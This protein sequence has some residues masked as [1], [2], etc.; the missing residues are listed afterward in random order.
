M[1]RL[2]LCERRTSLEDSC[3]TLPCTRVLLVSNWVSIVVPDGPVSIRTFS[4]QKR[5]QHPDH[6]GSII[7]QPMLA[8]EL[9]ELTCIRLAYQLRIRSEG[10][11][12][13]RGVFRTVR[14]S[15]LTHEYHL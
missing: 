4:V 13:A 9:L 15:S 6:Y 10:R 2:L 8:D 14:L 1:V 3:S 11:A 5:E 7:I 12:S